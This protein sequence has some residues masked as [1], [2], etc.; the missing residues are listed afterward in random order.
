MKDK[1]TEV[2]PAPPFKIWKV[3]LP[4]A[5]GMVAVAWMLWRDAESHD[6]AAEWRA[7]KFTPRM[8]FS[9]LLAFL[10]M[11]GRD[12]GLSWRFRAL[13]NGD[14]SWR[15]AIKVNLLCE[16]TSCVTPTSV[17]GSSMGMV[18]MNSEGIELGR[19]TT[20]MFT[21]LF[22]DELFFVVSCPIVVLLTPAGELFAGGGSEGFAHGLQLTFWVVYSIIAVWTAILFLGILVKP[23][24]IASMIAKLFS[25]RLLRRWQPAVITLGDNM[26]ATGRSLRNKPARFWLE[27]FGATALSWTSR[28]LVVNA[29]FMAFADV[30]SQQHWLIVARQLV[31]WVVLTASPTPGGSGLSEWLFTEYYGNMIASAGLALIMAVCWRIISYYV[32][33]IIGATI[34][35]K[36]LRDSYQKFR[37]KKIQS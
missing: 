16:F 28:Y 29:I 4:A 20:L 24:M 19:A 15:Q 13:T 11:V 30:S 6:L 37:N 25:L 1:A 32:Y 21:T 10:F 36:W 8:L 12:A 31:V 2:R 26:M 17:G 5:I 27:T 3:I 18:F 22:L 7:I 9:L 34:V 14:L 33:L 35:P 23:R